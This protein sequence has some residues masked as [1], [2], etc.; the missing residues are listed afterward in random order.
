MDFQ[1]GSFR[2][3]SEAASIGGDF[4]SGFTQQVTLQGLDW[5]NANEIDVWE[6]SILWPGETHVSAADLALLDIEK[7]AAN[8][9]FAAA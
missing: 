7:A 3:S 4:G 5:L 1:C 8:H 9:W 6:P 2:K